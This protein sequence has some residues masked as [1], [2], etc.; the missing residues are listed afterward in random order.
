M[1]HQLAYFFGELNRLLLNPML[2]G[3]G[4]SRLSGQNV[5]RGPPVQKRWINCTV[6]KHQ[7]M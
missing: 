3:F 4:L 5:N 6:S 2:G 1:A 7:V